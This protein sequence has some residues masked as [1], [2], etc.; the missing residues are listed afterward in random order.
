ML[1]ERIDK[2]LEQKDWQEFDKYYLDVET[3]DG[4][5]SFAKAEALNP[6]R[7][8]SFIVEKKKGSG[9]WQPLTNP[10]SV[11]NTQIAKPWQYVGVETDYSEKGRG[12]ITPQMITSVLT[13]AKT[14]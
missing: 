10:E 8:P 6:Q 5:V 12:I 2:L 7:I 3:V 13:Q 11:S 14:L 1:N 4:M 9:E